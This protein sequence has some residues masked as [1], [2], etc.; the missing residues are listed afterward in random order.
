MSIGGKLLPAHA[1][2][3][4]DWKVHFFSSA[5]PGDAEAREADRQF[6][7]NMESVLGPRAME[8]LARI[9]AVINL[10]YFGIDFS[11]DANG[12]VIVFEANATMNV[13][14]PDAGE[15]W[16]YRTDPTQT[17]GDYIRVLFFIKGFGGN[18]APHLRTQVLR[19]FT[20][21]RIEDHLARHPERIDLAIERARLL[22][23]MERFDEAKN[24]YLAILEKEP[25]QF[26]ALNTKRFCM[27][28]LITPTR[29]RASPMC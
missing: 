24:I 12:D 14:P 16:A 8:A 7:E 27:P 26:V 11:L 17:I 6:L 3:A 20:L 9:Q 29:T 10:D 21:R 1:A 25:Q 5:A 23:E 15:M 18:P 13:P 22:I 4:R 28:N 19:E 2:L